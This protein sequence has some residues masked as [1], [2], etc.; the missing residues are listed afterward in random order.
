M[1]DEMKGS[2]VEVVF[3]GMDVW[4]TNMYKMETISFYY[5]VIQNLCSYLHKYFIHILYTHELFFKN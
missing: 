1:K 4:N 2:E 3:I 5:I